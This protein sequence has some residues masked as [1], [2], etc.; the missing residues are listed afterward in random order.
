[1]VQVP[2]E[3]KLLDVD[4]QTAS[5]VSDTVAVQRFSWPV[6]SI[7]QRIMV[8]HNKESIAEI[9]KPIRRL[10]FLRMSAAERESYNVLVSLAKN[11]LVV[12]GLDYKTP[13]AQHLDSHLNPRNRKFATEAMANIR[14]ACCG[15]GH[16]GIFLKDHSLHETIAYMRH[17]LGLPDAFV[18]KV[19]EYIRRAEA[20]LTSDCE[21]CGIPLGLLIITP[22]AHLYCPECT[23]RMGD[24][25][26]IC[27]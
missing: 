5:I 22:C 24:Y 11:N 10:T 18:N 26:E 15:G 25:C 19:L 3:Q 4:E 7:L 14:V 9:P 20:G 1:M 12:T 17:R 13:G 23:E 27:R 8:R 2:H 16:S 21:W 6:Q